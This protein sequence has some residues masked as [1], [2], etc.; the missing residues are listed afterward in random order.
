[1]E[2]NESGNQHGYDEPALVARMIDLVSRQQR[3]TRSLAKL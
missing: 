1:M 3:M 2:L